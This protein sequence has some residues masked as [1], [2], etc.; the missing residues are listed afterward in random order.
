MVK[1]C[2]TAAGVGSLT[3]VEANITSEKYI[4]ELENNLLPA[5]HENF[6]ANSYIFMD[7]EQ[8]IDFFDI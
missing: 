8:N 5:I 2:I 6:D 7:T 3:R 1:G 4:N